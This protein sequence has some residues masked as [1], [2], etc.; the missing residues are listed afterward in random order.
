MNPPHIVSRVKQTLSYRHPVFAAP[1]TVFSWPT[2]GIKFSGNSPSNRSRSSTGNLP[3]PILENRRFI[4]SK[5]GLIKRCNK[6][7]H[8]LKC[9]LKNGL[10]PVFAYVLTIWLHN[11]SREPCL[12]LSGTPCPVP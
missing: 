10:Y 6:K 8:I 3:I 12:F 2:S 11:N 9:I 7:C 4:P 5:T 1:A